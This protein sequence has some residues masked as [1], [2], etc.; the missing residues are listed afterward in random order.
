MPSSEPILR[1]HSRD[2]NM[3]NLNFRAGLSFTIKLHKGSAGYFLLKFQWF[4][5]NWEL[6]WQKDRE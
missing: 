1:V 2:N 3:K 5:C 6:K 4:Q